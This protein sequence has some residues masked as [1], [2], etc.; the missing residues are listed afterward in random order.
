MPTF[1]NIQFD[2]IEINGVND[3]IQKENKLNYQ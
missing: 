2:K 1:F 3:E